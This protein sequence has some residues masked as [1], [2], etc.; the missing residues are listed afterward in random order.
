MSGYLLLIIWVALH[1][2]IHHSSFLC[3]GH[4]SFN[5]LILACLSFRIARSEEIIIDRHFNPLCSEAKCTT[6]LRGL[7]ESE[8]LLVR[9]HQCSQNSEGRKLEVEGLDIKRS[10]LGGTSSDWGESGHSGCSYLCIPRQ[11]EPGPSQ[12]ASVSVCHQTLSWEKWFP[13]TTCLQEVISNMH[14]LHVI[15]EQPIP[16]RLFL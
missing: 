10:G 3:T 13:R 16:A 5:C 14:L 9:Q 15:W 8:R 6:R 12:L 11:M 7:K 1:T 2:L 4:C